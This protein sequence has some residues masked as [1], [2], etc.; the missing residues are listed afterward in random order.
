[1]AEFPALLAKNAER[2]SRHAETRSR[3]W[4]QRAL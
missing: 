4:L 1:L 2:T 3:K